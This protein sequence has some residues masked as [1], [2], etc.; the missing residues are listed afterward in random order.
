M[1]S[2]CSVNVVVS[3]DLLFVSNLLLE[4]WVQMVLN[5][6]VLLQMLEKVEKVEK[7][8]E[9]VVELVLVVVLAETSVVVETHLLLMQ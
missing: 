2:F 1:P 4:Y 5:Q 3:L 6:V 9:E 8:K 7:K